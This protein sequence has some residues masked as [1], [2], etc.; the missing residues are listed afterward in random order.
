MSAMKIVICGSRADADL[1]CAR[2][3]DPARGFRCQILDQFH[4]TF[5][6]ATQVGA[7]SSMVFEDRFVVIGIRP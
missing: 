2:M 1:A 7:P 6:D 3:Q 5:W 4:D